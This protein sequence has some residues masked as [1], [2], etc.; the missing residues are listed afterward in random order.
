M[1]IC[2]TARTPKRK[3]ELLHIINKERCKNYG[4]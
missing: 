2:N 4:I 3:R 1:L